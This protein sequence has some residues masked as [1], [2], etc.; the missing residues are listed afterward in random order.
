M[1]SMVEYSR[2]PVAVRRQLKAMN[3]VTQATHKR[4]A[5]GHM[6]S[7]LQEIIDDPDYFDRDYYIASLQKAIAEAK[8][9]R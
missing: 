4:S 9:D 3:A 6:E 5:L 8:K 7:R 2:Q 1:I